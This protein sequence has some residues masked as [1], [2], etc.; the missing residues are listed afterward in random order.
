[1]K[2][3]DIAERVARIN[4]ELIKRRDEMSSYT[5]IR[6]NRNLQEEYFEIINEKDIS[7]VSNKCKVSIIIL[8][9]EPQIEKLAFTLESVVNQ[10]HIDFEILISDDGSKN[11]L[12]SENIEYLEAREFTDYSIVLHKF[13]V[14]TVKNIYDATLVAGGTYIKLISPGD[15]IAY[16]N[17]ISEWV[18]YLNRSG[19]RWSFGEAVYYKRNQDLKIELLSK[20]CNPQVT[21]CYLQHQDNICRMNYVGYDDITLGAATLCEKELMLRYLNRLI[22]KVIYAED[23]IYRI[24][25][26]DNC[27]AE[28]F[29]QIVV[30]YE[31]GLGVSTS[32]SLSWKEK[33]K[34]D[35]EETD[36]ILLNEGADNDIVQRKIKKIYGKRYNANRRIRKYLK[37][38][39]FWQ[40]R[41]IIKRRFLPRMSSTE[42]IFQDL[43]NK[44]SLFT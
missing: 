38:L 7:S 15:A 18:E 8:T 36:K 12:L 1:M 40:L 28:Y 9:Y 30:V 13:N 24:M 29:P 44:K 41:M 42:F 34:K 39:N 14:G 35:W 32:S 11:S 27:L 33:L 4:D 6:R 3:N 31:Y 43:G 2:P 16:D 22:G 20:P 21:K 5:I 17:T 37:L 23:N 25:M 10:K 26:F 19:R